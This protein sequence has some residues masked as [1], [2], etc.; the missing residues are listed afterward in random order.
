MCKFV[1]FSLKSSTRKYFVAKH[2]LLSVSPRCSLPLPV[3][4][5]LVSNTSRQRLVLTH[6]HSVFVL[7]CVTQVCN[8]IWQL[9]KRKCNKQS[10]NPLVT[11]PVSARSTAHF[12]GLSL[13]GISG[14]NPSGCLE[15]YLL[16]VLCVVQVEVFETSWSF[17]QRSPT[18]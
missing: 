4:S 2:K 16:S 6:P 9:V 14:L 17:V 3:T 10:R 15:V 11:V 8:F 7:Y 5:P 1:S 13:A 12:W 18:T